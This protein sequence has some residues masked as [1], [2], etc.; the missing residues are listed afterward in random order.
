MAYRSGSNKNYRR[1]KRYSYRR[2]RMLRRIAGVVFLCLL[3]IAAV[4]IIKREQAPDGVFYGQQGGILSQQTEHTG[5]ADGLLKVWFIDV[6]EGDAA[7]VECGGHYMLIDAG[8][9]DSAPAVQELL[10]SRGASSLDYVVATHPHE[11]HIGGIPEVLRSYPAHRIL[12]PVLESDTY[13]FRMMSAAAGREKLVKVSAGDRFVLG[14]NETGEAGA[15]SYAD[16]TVLGPISSDPLPENIN[17]ISIVLKVTFGDTSFLF[18][19]DAEYD[20]LES[21][22][23]REKN[24]EMTGSGSPGAGETALTCDCDVLKAAHH[25]SNDAGSFAFLES[26]SP[27]FTVIS[28]GKDNEHGHPHGRLLGMLED[29]DTTLFRTDLSGTI[30]ITSDG[31]GVKAY[32]EREAEYKELWEAGAFPGEGTSDAA[33]G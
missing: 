4:F 10:K 32:P 24:A 29:L 18:T 26:A 30:L 25:G 13:S 6:G 8:T 23:L 5:A 20:E 9:A 33:D 17:N 22:V 7:L 14:T 3:A 15:P 11:D 31:A 12:T 21:I 28:C 19:G 27:A 2:R 1:K 16:I